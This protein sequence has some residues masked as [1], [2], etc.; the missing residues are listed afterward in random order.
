[1]N[2]KTEQQKNELKPFIYF[3]QATELD[4]TELWNNRIAL[5]LARKA[6]SL[7]AEVEQF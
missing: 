4:D 6:C 5:E 2:S 3:I 1:M 7:S